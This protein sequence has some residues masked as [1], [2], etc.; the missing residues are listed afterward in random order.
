LIV[1][2]EQNINLGQ[3]DFQISIGIGNNCSSKV[4]KGRLNGNKK[5]SRDFDRYCIY[6]GFI[7]ILELQPKTA[8][9]KKDNGEEIEIPIE[10]IQLGDI[11][12]VRP[13]E[14]VPVDSNVILGTS[15]VDESMV[16]GESMPVS[17]KVGDSVIGGSINREG[18]IVI[19]AAKIGSD[20]F[21]SQVVKLVEEAV[22]R[23]PAIQKMVDKVAGYFAYVVLIAALST[24]VVWYFVLSH[25]MAAMAL[26]PT[27][28]ILVVA[29]PCAL[30]L[31]TPTAIMVGM[32][33]GSVKWSLIQKW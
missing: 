9:V 30:G 12:V 17:K 32:G 15:A 13:G 29:C 26:I 11:I 8:K 18:M 1:N 2:G 19:K 22:G 4:S 33:K 3:V 5:Y 25:G 24:F 23:K 6:A 31:A 16:T 7:I 10:H 21:L 14:K 28:A 27:V 20:S